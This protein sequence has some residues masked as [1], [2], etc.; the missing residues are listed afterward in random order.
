MKKNGF[1]L[2]SDGSVK[3]DDNLETNIKGVFAAG[4]LTGEVRVI[5]K[6][7][8]EGI[9]VAVHAFEEIKIPYWLK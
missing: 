6:T 9:V 8:A 5:A 4:D 1:M 3:V 7:C 2:Q